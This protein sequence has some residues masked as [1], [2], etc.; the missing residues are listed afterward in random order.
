MEAQLFVVG[1]EVQWLI[2]WDRYGSKHPRKDYG[3]R[4]GQILIESENSP[5]PSLLEEGLCKS[6]NNV[7]EIPDISVAR[8]PS[9]ACAGWDRGHKHNK[10]GN[11]RV[12]ETG[13]HLTPAAVCQ[14][15]TEANGQSS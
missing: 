4:T 10:K 11:E 3:P 2:S 15:G 6:R 12:T 8:C 5:T 9:C 14:R 13:A 7:A 1:G